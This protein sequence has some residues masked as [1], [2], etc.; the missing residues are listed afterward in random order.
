MLKHIKPVILLISILLFGFSYWGTSTKEGQ[1]Q[2]DE[3]DGLIPLFSAVLATLL[4]LI[5][6]ILFVRGLTKKK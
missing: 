1:K 5:F 2:Y 3:M 6:I 4:F